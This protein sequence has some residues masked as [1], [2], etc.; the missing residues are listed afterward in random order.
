MEGEAVR[1]GKLAIAVALIIALWALAL[2]R[3]DTT[4]SPTPD[5]F[6]SYFLEGELYA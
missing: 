1:L 6:T 4:P 5:Q 3:A 2:S